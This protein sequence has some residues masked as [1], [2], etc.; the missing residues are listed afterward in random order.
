MN[1]QDFQDR[2]SE[3]VDGT[4]APDDREAFCSHRDGCE[5]CREELSLFESALAAVDDAFPELEPSPLFVAQVWERIR[6]EPPAPAGWR[7][8]LAGWLRW[9]PSRQLSLA[10]ASLVL[11][12]TGLLAVPA[13]RQYQ[14]NHETVEVAVSEIIPDARLTHVELMPAVP[15]PE[16]VAILLD[17]EPDLPD[18]R[19][20]G[21]PDMEGT[22]KILESL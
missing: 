8:V 11:V 20:L 12:L 21:N 13:V 7:Q 22:D 18:L 15:D 4:L 3:Y 17:E 2:L 19:L 6:Q 10:L 5:G 14:Q 16:L 1:C 9:S